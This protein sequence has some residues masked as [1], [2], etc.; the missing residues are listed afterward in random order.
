[1]ARFAAFLALLIW[2]A[3]LGAAAQAPLVSETFDTGQVEGS[4]PVGFQVEQPASTEVRV[5]G[6]L[7]AAGSPPF[8]LLLGDAAPVGR[9]EAHRTLDRDVEAGSLRVRVHVARPSEAPAGVQL[10]SRTGRYLGAVLMSDNGRVGYDRGAGTVY[11]DVLWTSDAWSEL[12]IDWFS[13]GTFD[14]YLG[15]QRVAKRIAFA[16]AAVPGRVVLTCGYGSGHGQRCHFDDLVASELRDAVDFQRDAAG[17]TPGGFWIDAPHGTA[18]QVVAEGPAQHLRLT[19]ASAGARATAVRSFAKA[20]EGSASLD[21][22]L[23]A[24]EAGPFDVQLR[25]DSHQFLAAVRLGSDGKV[26]FH[27]HPGGQGAFTSTDASWQSG[28]AHAL[29]IVWNGQDRFAAFLDGVCVVRDQALAAP[30]DPAEL[31]LIAGTRTTVAAASE[32]DDLVVRADHVESVRGRYQDNALWLAHCY[33]SSPRCIALLPDLLTR[34]DQ[35]YGV[36][37]LFLNVGMLDTSGTLASAASG[38]ARLPEFFEAL[39]EHERATGRRYH[40]VAW[41]NGL[42]DPGTAGALALDVSQTRANIAAEAVRLVSAAVQGSHV[43]DTVRAFDG[44]QLD[45]EP[46]GPTPARDAGF[47]DLLQ[48]IRSGW[49]A[50]GIEHSDLGIAAHAE[51]SNSP[52]RWEAEDFRDIAPLVDHL[53]IMTYSVGIEDGHAYRSWMEAQTQTILHAVAGGTR[54][55][56]GLPAHGRTAHHEPDAENVRW[57]A[58]GVDRAVSTML[59]AADPA[60]AAFAGVAMYLHHDGS[61]DT[62]YASWS[63][64][65]WWLGRHW[66]G[67]W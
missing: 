55:F 26:A 50:A 47:V 48:R 21:V 3:P 36:N 43:A 66:L 29:H 51:G 28:T 58:P 65:Y 23:P 61:A 14:A 56:M 17:A 9:P 52:W 41:I 30:G 53:G 4:A 31:V 46:S 42:L 39:T 37:T 13:D 8:S 40:V 59:N 24:R 6:E 7:F 20:A 64:D 38:L 16:T 54:V 63:T 60:V 19:D 32:V 12:R 33:T 1:M 62:G 34:L 35:H 10:R 44:V 5:S 22:S 18:V 67:A 15:A 11:A 25:S 57:G 45:L 49:A 2:S 27:N